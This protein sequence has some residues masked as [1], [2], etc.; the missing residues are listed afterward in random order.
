MSKASRAGLAVAILVIGAGVYL[1]IFHEPNYNGSALIEL[2]KT[3]PEDLQKRIDQQKRGLDASQRLRAIISEYGRHRNSLPPEAVSLSTEVT[4]LSEE[5][6][7]KANQGTYD[8]KRSA[9][10]MEKQ[11]ELSAILAAALAK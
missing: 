3:S 6:T 4:A 9:I 2:G 11:N 1:K 5:L 10:L 7:I 8:E